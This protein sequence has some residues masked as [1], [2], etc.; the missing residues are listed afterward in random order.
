MLAVS[1]F[2]VIHIEKDSRKTQGLSCGH[3]GASVK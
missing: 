3:S 1:T 2:T